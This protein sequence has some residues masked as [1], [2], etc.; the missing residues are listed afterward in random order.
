M[1]LVVI[2]FSKIKPRTLSIKLLKNN[3]LA[4]LIKDSVWIYIVIFFTSL[5]N[6]TTNVMF[7]LESTQ[8]IWISYLPFS[9]MRNWKRRYF[10]LEEN[11]MSYFKSDSV[12]NFNYI[13]WRWSGVF[14]SAWYLWICFKL[15]VL[16]EVTAF[17]EP[18]FSLFY[19]QTGIHC[20]HFTCSVMSLIT[21]PSLYSLSHT[22]TTH[23]LSWG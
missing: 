20:L 10:L 17:K 21:W 15:K 19:S 18:S 22:H 5:F 16:D 11:A 12:I 8:T 4:T 23:T 6:H 3:E 9:Q 1:S 13:I 7:L 2:K 14:F